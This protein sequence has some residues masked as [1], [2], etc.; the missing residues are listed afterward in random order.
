MGSPINKNQRISKAAHRDTVFKGYVDVDNIQ[1]ER[2]F[3]VDGAAT[4]SLQ[5]SYICAQQQRDPPPINPFATKTGLKDMS[6]ITET[7][8]A[9][10]MMKLL[11]RPVSLGVRTIT[12][13]AGVDRQR[14]GPQTMH[15]ADHLL[16]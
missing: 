16:M 8:S 3:T 11:Q 1:E 10:S 14:Q 4:R 15:E 13:I 7:T 9:Q 12:L 5:D 2:L 6:V